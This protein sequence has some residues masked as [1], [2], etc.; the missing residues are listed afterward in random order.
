MQA[1]PRMELTGWAELAT[2]PNRGSAAAE[3]AAAVVAV[4]GAPTQGLSPAAEGAPLPGG[5]SPLHATTRQ[6]L[7]WYQLLHLHPTACDVCI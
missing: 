1:D 2:T 5:D 7:M 4:A 6:P 3:V